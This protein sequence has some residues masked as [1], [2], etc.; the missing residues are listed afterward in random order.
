MRRDYYIIDA[1][2]LDNKSRVPVF[3]PSGTKFTLGSRSNVCAAPL[4]TSAS[5]RA[6]ITNG[7]RTRVIMTY[8]L[9]NT[10]VT[11]ARARVWLD[12]YA[13]VETTDG[14]RGGQYIPRYL[15]ERLR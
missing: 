1:K 8:A 14:G 9:A 10:L 15:G 2:N 7:A 5:K 3:I 13:F 4:F 11:T 12:E 6:T